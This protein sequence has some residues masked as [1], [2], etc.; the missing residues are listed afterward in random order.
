MFL[1]ELYKAFK[2]FGGDDTTPIGIEELRTVSEQLG[3]K[4]TNEELEEMIFQTLSVE[5]K[6]AVLHAT[7]KLSDQKCSLGDFLKMMKK[8]G[9][10]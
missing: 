1:Q 9:Q 5:Q 6:Q 8:T 7:I 4:M 10:C 3:M 2:Q